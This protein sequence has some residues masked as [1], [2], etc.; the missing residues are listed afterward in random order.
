MLCNGL[1]PVAF[2][3]ISLVLTRFR[4][5]RITNKRKEKIMGRVIKMNTTVETMMKAIFETV[6]AI[7]TSVAGSGVL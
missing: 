2:L 7:G 3:V 4:L 1:V 6:W 5:N